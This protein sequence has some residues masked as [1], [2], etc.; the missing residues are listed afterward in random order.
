MCVIVET[1]GS[2]CVH[3]NAM[4]REKPPEQDMMGTPVLVIVRNNCKIL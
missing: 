1:N 4:F 2:S 3:V